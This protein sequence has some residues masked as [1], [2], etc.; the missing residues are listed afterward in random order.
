MNDLVE[1]LLL[2]PGWIRH[3]LVV[4]MGVLCVG[5]TFFTPIG[6]SL[7]LW[8]V[9]GIALSIDFMATVMGFLK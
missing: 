2:M 9:F 7:L 8:L 6:A 1:I 3:L 4:L 5:L